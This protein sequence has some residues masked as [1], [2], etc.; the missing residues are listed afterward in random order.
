MKLCKEGEGKGGLS[1][2]DTITPGL[3]HRSM[4]KI[5]G[6][7]EKDQNFCDA[8][9]ERFLNMSSA[10]PTMSHPRFQVQACRE[11]RKGRVRPSS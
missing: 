2:S 6:G 10:L 8:I 4:T 3:Q 11:H 9:L 7:S 5:G 1:L